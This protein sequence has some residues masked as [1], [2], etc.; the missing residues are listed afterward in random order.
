[1]PSGLRC[2][3]AEIC[4]SSST[5]CS[6][7]SVWSFIVRARWPA[8]FGSLQASPGEV[9]LDTFTELRY[10]VLQTKH[11]AWIRDIRS[12]FKV[13]LTGNSQT[14]LTRKQTSPISTLV[15]DPIIPIAAR[16]LRSPTSMIPWERA[17]K[18]DA[19]N[20]NTLLNEHHMP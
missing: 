9:F 7:V 20:A 19:S 4:N 16:A 15:A 3:S 5:S 17:L 8:W 12:V 18:S 11:M 2:D 13:D 10:R 6:S 14:F 1:M